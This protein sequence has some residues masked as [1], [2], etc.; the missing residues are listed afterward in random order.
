MDGSGPYLEGDFVA[1]RGRA[2]KPSG[3][4]AEVGVP[5]LVDGARGGRPRP[6]LPQAVEAVGRLRVQAQA[7]VVPKQALHLQEGKR[8]VNRRSLC[9]KY[10]ESSLGPMWQENAFGSADPA[11]FCKKSLWL[12]ASSNV[13]I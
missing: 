2:A 8:G 10:R 3:G 1:H 12:T 13:Q 11:L 7:E 6:L 4:A 5:G 9:I